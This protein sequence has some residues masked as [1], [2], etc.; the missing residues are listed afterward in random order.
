[1]TWSIESDIDEIENGLKTKLGL[2]ISLTYG[3]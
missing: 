1:M 2:T 3:S